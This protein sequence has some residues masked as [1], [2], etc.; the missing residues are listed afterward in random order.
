MFKFP[1]KF[2]LLEL[3]TF[4][5][6]NIYMENMQAFKKRTILLLALNILI[7]LSISNNYNIFD[8][9]WKDIIVI[10]LLTNS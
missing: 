4:F 5:I 10:L 2:F 3:C 6:T 7:T 8:N 9:K 1:K